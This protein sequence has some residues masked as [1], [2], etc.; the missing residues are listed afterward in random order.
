MKLGDVLV[1]NFDADVVVRVES[2]GKSQEISK[3]ESLV[4]KALSSYFVLR[5]RSNKTL[6]IN[7]NRKVDGGLK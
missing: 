6:Y 5:D 2:L 1:K 7:T 4:Y 3:I